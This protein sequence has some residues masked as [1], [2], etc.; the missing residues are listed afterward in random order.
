MTII[1]NKQTPFPDDIVSMVSNLEVVDR[2]L[3]TGSTRNRGNDSRRGPVPLEIP[4]RRRE[5]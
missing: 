4:R 5:G 1:M 2:H 3:G